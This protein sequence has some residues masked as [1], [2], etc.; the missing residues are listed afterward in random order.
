MEGNP[1]LEVN[2]EG[3]TTVTNGAF[4]LSE[5]VLPAGGTSMAGIPTILCFCLV[6]GEKPDPKHRRLAQ[7][8]Q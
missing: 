3:W 8:H 1:P 5:Q 7:D 4:Q 2:T 6:E